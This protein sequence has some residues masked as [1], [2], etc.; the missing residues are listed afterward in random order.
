[1]DRVLYLGNRRAAIGT[2]DEV[3]TPEVL[4]QLYDMPIEVL[5]TKDRIVVVAGHGPV[6]GEAHRHDV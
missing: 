2:V 1:M 4:S 5:R 3:V 6:E